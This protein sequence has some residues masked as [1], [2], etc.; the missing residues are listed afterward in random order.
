MIPILTTIDYKNIDM[1]NNIEVYNNIPQLIE[2]SNKQLSEYKNND[3]DNFIAMMNT[4]KGRS[5]AYSPFAYAYICR[6]WCERITQQTITITLD[7]NDSYGQPIIRQKPVPTTIERF[8]HDT[9]ITR[10]LFTKYLNA[11]NEVSV[12]ANLKQYNID[13]TTYD[14]SDNDMLQIYEDSSK[15]IVNFCIANLLENS[16]LNTLS[17]NPATLKL[18]LV[19]LAGYK[20]VSVVEHEVSTKELPPFM[21]INAKPVQSEDIEYESIDNQ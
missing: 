14:M 9:G 12:L 2:Q 8:V 20:D 16:A 10:P 6:L 17:I 5:K 19:N 13:Y 15:M 21:R 18:M 4:T 11:S 1:L 3:M 7:K